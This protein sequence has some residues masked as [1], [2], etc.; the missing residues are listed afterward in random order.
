MKT[1]INHTSPCSIIHQTSGSNSKVTENLIHL[2]PH[3]HCNYEYTPILVLL[4][5][6]LLFAFSRY[7]YYRWQQETLFVLQLSL[8][9]FQLESFWLIQII[10]SI[11]MFSMSEMVQS[12][13]NRPIWLA[14]C[15]NITQTLSEKGLFKRLNIGHFYLNSQA[16]KYSLYKNKL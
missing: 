5:L 7:N 9:T 12:Y 11:S 16:I 1:A 4:P 2:I 3:N 8:R 13:S 14:S 10:S 6:A 15:D